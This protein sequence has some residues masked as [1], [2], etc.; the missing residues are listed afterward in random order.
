MQEIF[1]NLICIIQLISQETYQIIKSQE[2][3]RE[4]KL[5]R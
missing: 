4:H 2:E 1:I 5:S 3:P